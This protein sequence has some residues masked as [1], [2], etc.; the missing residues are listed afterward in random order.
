MNKN[1]IFECTNVHIFF[2][3]GNP[4]TWFPETHPPTQI[5][6]LFEFVN[7]YVMLDTPL[8]EHPLF[9]HSLNQVE[10]LHIPVHTELLYISNHHI[11]Y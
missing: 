3:A 7:P 6:T 5:W 8:R 4:S 11:S 9:V 2:F 10:T 1:S